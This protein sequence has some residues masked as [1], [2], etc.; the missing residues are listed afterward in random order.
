M[1][2]NIESAHCCRRTYNVVYTVHQH[3]LGKIVP[4][5][6]NIVSNED[7][8]PCPLVLTTQDVIYY[9]RRRVVTLTV[10]PDCSCL[11]PLVSTE[12]S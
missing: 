5:R 4:K 11:P 9:T 2:Q 10:Q 8:T 3:V 1:S 12:S 6:T 7:S